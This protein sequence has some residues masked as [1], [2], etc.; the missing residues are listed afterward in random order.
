MFSI[1]A[2]DGP[3][4]PIGPV[5]PTGPVNPFGPVPPVGPVDPIPP[6]LYPITL[7]DIYH[8]DTL[9]VPPSEYIE[10]ATPA[11]VG[12]LVSESVLRLS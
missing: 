2:P 7:F 11:E 10:P 9:S 4:T 1:V 3:L 5:D 12:R 6:K 8:P